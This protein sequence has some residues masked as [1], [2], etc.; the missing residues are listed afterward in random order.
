MCIIHQEINNN[1]KSRKHNGAKLK[2]KNKNKKKYKKNW[3]LVRGVENQCEDDKQELNL[4]INSHKPHESG[5]RNS[6]T[7]Y[8][9]HMVEDCG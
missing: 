4:S 7:S 9:E 8:D 2:G 6:M 1:R 5:N 3:R